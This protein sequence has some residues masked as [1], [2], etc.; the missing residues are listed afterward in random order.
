MAFTLS[1]QKSNRK[2]GKTKISITL[3]EQLSPEKKREYICF[4][5]KLSNEKKKTELVM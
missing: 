1:M 2:G 5:D 4:Y 3:N